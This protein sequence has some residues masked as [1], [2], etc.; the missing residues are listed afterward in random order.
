M[1]KSLLYFIVLGLL[2]PLFR[3]KREHTRRSVNKQTAYY[4]LVPGKYIDFAYDSIVYD[5]NGTQTYHYSG[6]I[7]EK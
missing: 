7:R 2:P 4:P 5:E 6:F 3:A 1:R